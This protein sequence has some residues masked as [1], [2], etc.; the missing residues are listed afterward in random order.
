MT[1][2]RASIEAAAIKAGLTQQ[3]M[4]DI[5]QRVADMADATKH[6]MRKFG[7][8]LERQWADDPNGPQSSAVDLLNK[9]LIARLPY[10]HAKGEEP[11][12]VGAED[13]TAA[14]LLVEEAR[15]DATARERRIIEAARELGLTWKQIAAAIGLDSPQAAQQRYERL[16]GRAQ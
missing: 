15:R 8:R 4:D 1:D 11:P 10:G 13:V 3:D 12:A 6:L 5:H 2:F 7:D 9:V 16:G 14:L